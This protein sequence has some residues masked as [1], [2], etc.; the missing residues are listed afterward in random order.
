MFR[1]SKLT[2]ASSTGFLPELASVIF[3][4][5]SGVLS[6][7]GVTSISSIGACYRGSSGFHDH[8][9]PT[10]GNFNPYICS[11]RY[12]GHSVTAGMVIWK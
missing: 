1:V 2:L 8:N 9:G 3:S 4:M 5:V 7:V 11:G 12:A 10:P 6:G